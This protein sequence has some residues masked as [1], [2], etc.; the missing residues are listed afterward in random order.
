MSKNFVK[1]AHTSELLPGQ[2]KPV[3]LGSEQI[4]VVNVAGSY[5]AVGD[6]CP[7]SYA[8]LSK[9]QIYGDEVVC[10]LHGSTFDIRT[11]EVISKP[12]LEGLT[13]YQIRVEGN[14]ILVAPQAKT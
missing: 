10:P 8:L 1:V 9:G 12:A 14:E 3:Q 11:G 5:Y 13:V 6:I 2:K 7:H 4:L